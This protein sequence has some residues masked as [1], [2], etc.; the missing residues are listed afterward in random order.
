MKVKSI[1]PVF[2]ESIPDRIDEGFLYISERYKTAI[3]KCCC[4]CGQEVVTP[5]SPAEWSIQRNGSQVSLWPSVGNWSFPCRS[6]YVIRGNSVLEAA[7]MNQRQV[8]RVKAKDRADKTAWVAQ[9][10]RDKAVKT[11]ESAPQPRTESQ[12]MRPL[13]QLLHWWRSL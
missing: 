1:T 3:H 5:L 6:H 7:P 8:Q 2:V 12:N 10:N 9:T 11:D 13:Q 4:G